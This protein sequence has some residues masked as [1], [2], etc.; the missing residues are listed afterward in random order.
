MD[1]KPKQSALRLPSFGDNWVDGYENKYIVL[2]LKH[3]T[4]GQFAF[5]KADCLGYTW[6][7]FNAGIYDVSDIEAQMQYFND[8]IDAIAVP[9]TGHALELL[10]LRVLC[11]TSDNV[12][13]R[14]LNISS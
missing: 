6:Y 11:D 8:G 1:A 4:P 10:N 3:S 9:L 2:S 14:F 12:L 13:S 7:L 5:W